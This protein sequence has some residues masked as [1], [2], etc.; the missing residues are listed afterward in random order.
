MLKPDAVQRG[1]VGE[2]IS[3]FEDKGLKIVGL[4]MVRI[5]LEQVKR[6]YACHEGKPFYDSLISFMTSGPAVAM[7]IEGRSAIAISRKVMGATD[8]LESVPGS[9]RGDYSVDYKHNLIHGSDSISSFQH[10]MPIYFSE[11]ELHDYDLSLK[12]W[13]YYY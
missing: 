13:L 1:K 7:V 5:S 9:I 12:G 4:K 11:C 10:E 6:Q 8:P 3:R 2:L